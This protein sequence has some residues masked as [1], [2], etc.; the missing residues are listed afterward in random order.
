MAKTLAEL[1]PNE[2]ERLLEQT[3][4]NRLRVWLIQLMDALTGSDVEEQAAFKPEFTDSLRR[5]LEQAA[6]GEGIE[7]EAFRKEIKR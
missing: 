7:L 1:S 4:D 5:S 2:F 6:S 3:I